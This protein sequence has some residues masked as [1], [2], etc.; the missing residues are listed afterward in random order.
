M[1]GVTHTELHQNLE[2]FEVNE[3]LCGELVT[4]FLHQHLLV[5]IP[6]AKGDERAYIAEH[7]LPD[8]L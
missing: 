4:E 5:R 7:R 1:L 2:T 3:H 8:G 6:D